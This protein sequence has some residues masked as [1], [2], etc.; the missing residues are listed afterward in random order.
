MALTIG[1]QTYTATSVYDIVGVLSQ[2]TYP[3]CTEVKR[4]YLDRSQLATL[5]YNGTTIN[6]C[7]YDDILN[8]QQRGPQIPQLQ[9]RQCLGGD[10]FAGGNIG[11]LSY[12]WDA[13]NN[14]KAEA[15][16]G[17][18]SDSTT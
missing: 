2:L 12:T 18:I 16:T 9:E 10:F 7:T 4:G 8:L 13:N 3:G 11:N 5:G 1:G 6:T 14:K 15:I 17:T